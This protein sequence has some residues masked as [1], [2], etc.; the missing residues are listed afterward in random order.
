MPAC[1]SSPVTDLAIAETRAWLDLAVL[2]LDLCPF[3]RGPH[4]AGRVRF[5][6]CEAEEP[7]ALLRVLES[8]MALLAATDP[9]TVE[10]TLLVHPRV[11]LD[12]LDYNDFLDV[13]DAALTALG[14]DGVLQ[15]ASFHPDYRFAGTELDDLGN[16]TNRSPYPTLQLLR[17]A[18]I[19]RAIGSRRGTGSGVGADDADDEADNIGT[20]I[21][22]A[23][24]AA[25]LRTLQTLGAA[26]WTALRERCRLEAAAAVAAG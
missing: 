11:L 9:S 6:C 3:A 26:G 5:V 10:T 7:E 8:E 14:L 17:E 20:E 12:F 2:G 18:S 25:N 21:A 13:A 16:A 15:I 19:E 24:V 22:D 4:A 1:N 23:I